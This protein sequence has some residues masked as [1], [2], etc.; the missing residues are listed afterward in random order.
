M[1]FLISPIFSASAARSLKIVS[2]QDETLIRRLDSIID[3]VSL[4][5]EVCHL[6]NTR[7]VYAYDIAFDAVNKNPNDPEALK[8]LG[9]MIGQ[10][11]NR[12]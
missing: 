3:G 6:E 12:F 11:Y 8:A 2:Q 5:D 1:V 10:T 4:F 7:D 9:E